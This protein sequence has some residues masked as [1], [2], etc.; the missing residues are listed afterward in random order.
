MCHRP[1]FAALD[2][3]TSLLDERAESQMMQLLLSRGVT[4]IS[5]AHRE[6]LGVHCKVDFAVRLK[7]DLAVRLPCVCRA[8]AVR[9][10]SD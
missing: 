10:P 6:A 7:V 9:L 1:R 8:F 3:A 4:L 2:E 5:V